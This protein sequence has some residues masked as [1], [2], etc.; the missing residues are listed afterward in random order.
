MA[1]QLRATYTGHMTSSAKKI[2]DEALALPAEDR[3]AIT[4]ALDASLHGA[5]VELSTEWLTEIADRIEK[6]RSGD[7]TVLDARAHLDE[8]R[9]KHG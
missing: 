1:E 8:L 2:L 9:A 4:E 5:D 6:A 7:A 3:G